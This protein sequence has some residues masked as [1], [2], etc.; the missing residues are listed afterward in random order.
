MR[1]LVLAIAALLARPR[2]R[3]ARPVRMPSRASVAPGRPR[4]L[5]PRCAAPLRSRRRQL[6]RARDRRVP[7][8]GRAPALERLARRA[9][10]ARGRPRRPG[11]LE[12]REPVV[13]G[14]GAR[15]SSTACTAASRA[16][17]RRSSRARPGRCRRSASLTYAGAPGIIPRRAW[18]GTDSGYRRKVPARYAPRRALR[19]RP[20][21]R[22]REPGDAAQSAAMVRAIA[23]YHV[24][25]N[26][27]DDIGYNF[28][29]DRFGQIFEGRY[30]GID[31]PV[32]G[33]HAEGFNDG[34]VGVALIGTYCSA[35]PSAA[36]RAALVRLLAWRLDLAHVDP[37]STVPPRPAATRS[38]GPA[39]G[40]RCARSR[41]TVTPATRP[42]PGVGLRAPAEHR[43]RVASD[44]PAQAVLAA[45]RAASRAGSSTSRAGSPA[46]SPWRV[47]VAD[48]DGHP[49]RERLR[50]R[51]G[52]RL[53]VGR[54][55]AFRPART[56][57]RSRGRRAAGDR[58]VQR[59]H[60]GA[61][62]HGGRVA[63]RR[64]ARRRRPRRHGARSRYRLGRASTVTATV[65]DPFGDVPVHPAAGPADGRTHSLTLARRRARGRAVL[66]PPHRERPAERATTT[67]AASAS[68]ARSR[69]LAA[70]R[71]RS[72][73]TATGRRRPDLLV[74]AHDAG[75][76]AS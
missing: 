67:V 23:V 25:S 43:R 48:A 63:R 37:L 53:D 65:L 9:A 11:P 34:S 12:D 22:R 40:S 75:R 49:G 70:R 62:H 71:R 2:G 76:R 74:R 16:C 69:R 54:D 26:G 44:G 18:A 57:G 51:D 73:R 8:P 14:P 72:R 59:R 45:R 28:L 50:L 19:G 60:G 17:G 21:H 6:A 46:R 10:R 30:G 24:Y 20:P 68:T 5:T 52:D 27:W 33:A 35:S 42:V 41:A 15:R 56:T 7:R 66:G 61:R 3:A 1:A 47:D 13:D 36:A 29:V 58:L 39:S 38:T 64:L 4:V 55:P 31:R 32:I